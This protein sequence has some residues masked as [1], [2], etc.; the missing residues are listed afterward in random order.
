VLAQ[1][2]QTSLES[3]KAKINAANKA[4]KI[5]A[6]GKKNASRIV[7][8]NIVGLMY[9]FVIETYDAV[10]RGVIFDGLPTKVLRPHRV[11]ERTILLGKLVEPSLYE[12]AGVEIRIVD[13]QIAGEKPRCGGCGSDDVEFVETTMNLSDTLGFAIRVT[14]ERSHYDISAIR[15]CRRCKLACLAKH[16]WRDDHA[17]VL[18]QLREDSLALYGINVEQCAGPSGGTVLYRPTK[19]LCS[20]I[21][22]ALISSDAGGQTL[23]TWISTSFS[24]AR[25]DNHLAYSAAL[26]AQSA[27]AEQLA[28]DNQ[29]RNQLPNRFLSSSFGRSLR[30]V[31]LC[32]CV[33]GHF[34]GLRG[35]IT[36]H[37]FEN[38]V[39]IP[40]LP[41]F[42]ET[43]EQRNR[44]RRLGGHGSGAQGGPYASPK[45]SSR[46][47]G[48]QPAGAQ[49]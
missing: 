34:G 15:S 7:P 9:D 18:T 12:I 25:S 41:A 37:Q 26:A 40:N 17:A 44:R 28:G 10:K 32:V 36:S 45:R 5:A 33:N 16:R 19:S 13:W 42:C 22:K 21:D 3:T 27:I 46:V 43:G 11:S 30:C 8:P 2:P 1:A 35:R 47:Q 20:L 4:A 38:R 31:C 24:E 29:C 48:G 49:V 14:A 23:H 39:N 6:K